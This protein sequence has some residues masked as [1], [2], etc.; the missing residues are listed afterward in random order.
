MCPFLHQFHDNLATL[1]RVCKI[2]SSCIIDLFYLPF[3]LIALVDTT[4]VSDILLAIPTLCI[5]Q[6]LK[7]NRQI[8]LIRSTLQYPRLNAKLKQDYR[9][10]RLLQVTLG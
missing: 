8:N 4:A 6:A 5:P 10:T 9:L 3:S 1:Y 2:A 7:Q